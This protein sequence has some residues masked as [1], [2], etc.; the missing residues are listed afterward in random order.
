[1]Y[2]G[3]S[4]HNDLRNLIEAGLT[5]FQALMAGMS[6]A[7]SFVAKTIPE[8]PVLGVVRIGA[9]ADLILLEH[10]PLDEIAKLWD[11]LGV[12]VRG[13]W[14]TAADLRHRMDRMAAD[15]NDGHEN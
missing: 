6:N 4:I 7:G 12:I 11:P 9:D 3:Y 13:T 10:N 15:Y 1:M 8:G 14:W 5:P 2:R